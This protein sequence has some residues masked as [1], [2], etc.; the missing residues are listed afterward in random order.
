MEEYLGLV[1][2]VLE[3]GA[4]KQNR[5]GVATISSFSCEYSIDLSDGFPLLTTKKL[6]GYRWD[7]LIYR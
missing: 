2:T 1:R 4:F 5:T 6:D 7:S 3:E